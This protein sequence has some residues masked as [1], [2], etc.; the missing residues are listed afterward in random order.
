MKRSDAE[1][2]IVADDGEPLLRG[3]ASFRLRNALDALKSIATTG[4]SKLDEELLK[5]EQSI[6]IVFNAIQ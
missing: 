3:A 6:R 2:K 1:L 5:A 4:D